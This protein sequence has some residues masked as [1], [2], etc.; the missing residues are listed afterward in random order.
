MGNLQQKT[1]K[2]ND[3]KFHFVKELSSGATANI[4]V[5]RSDKTKKLHVL[6]RMLAED[7]ARFNKIMKEIKIMVCFL[8]QTLFFSERATQTS[9]KKSLG[10]HKNVVQFQGFRTKTEEGGFASIYM[11]L[12]YCEMDLTELMNQ[13]IESGT[14][15]R[16]DE[17]WKIFTDVTKA[18][19]RWNLLVLILFL[20]F[21][22]VLKKKRYVREWVGLPVKTLQSFIE[23]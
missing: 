7:E 11:L 12:E 23:T 2:I 8:P 3:E 13:K 6:K 15:F 10:E 1:I 22:W 9:N 4:Y 16:E 5:V 21:W 19:S 14:K 17:I 20:L 18:P